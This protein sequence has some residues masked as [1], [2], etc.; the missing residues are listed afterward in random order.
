MLNGKF[1]MLVIVTDGLGGL[2]VSNGPML[3]AYPD[4]MGGTLDDIV[5]VLSKDELKDVFESFYIL[6]SIFNTDL[7]RGFSVIDYGI[8]E[9]LG[10]KEAIEAIK[11]MGIDLKLDFISLTTHLYYQRSSR[12]SSKMVRILSTRISSLTGTNSGKVAVLSQKRDTFS[13][14][15]NISRTCFSASQVYQFLW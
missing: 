8:N 15:K 7:D 1:V 3:N 10:S 9:E 12:I 13:Q 2:I 5:K 4:S 11:D 6:P 14:M